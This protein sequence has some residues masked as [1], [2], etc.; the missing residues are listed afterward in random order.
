MFKP[1]LE[2]HISL[3]PGILS[4]SLSLSLLSSSIH[5]HLPFFETLIL[6]LY[7]LSLWLTQFLVLAHRAKEDR[8]TRRRNRL[9]QIP[10]SDFR[11][12]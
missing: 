2:T 11:G 12:I 1:D 8:L 3:L 5:L 10:V 7:L 4:L 6:I 9:M